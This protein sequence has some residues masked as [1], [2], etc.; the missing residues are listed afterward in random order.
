M[1]SPFF[2][3][4]GNIGSMEC[5]FASDM[6]KIHSQQRARLSNQNNIRLL[7]QSSAI[8]S[9]THLKSESIMKLTAAIHPMEAAPPIKTPSA[10]PFLYERKAVAANVTVS[11]PV[12]ST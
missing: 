2:R 6:E 3:L 8:A 10:A 5:E 9:K 1:L 11:V 12:A 7:A 4:R